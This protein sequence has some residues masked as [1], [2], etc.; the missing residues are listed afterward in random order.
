MITLI[1]YVLTCTATFKMAE[2][3]VEEILLWLSLSYS[4]AI[5]RLQQ[6]PSL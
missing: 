5:L 1:L 3:H 4:G 2:D 6:I